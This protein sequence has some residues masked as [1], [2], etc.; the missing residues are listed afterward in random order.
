[1]PEFDIDAA[2]AARDVME[3]T[4]QCPSGCGGVLVTNGYGSFSSGATPEAHIWVNCSRRGLHT[5]HDFKATYRFVG[6]C[7]NRNPLPD[8]GRTHGQ[9]PVCE[10]VD[11]NEHPTDF[12]AVTVEHGGNAVDSLLEKR[13]F[14]R[15]RCRVER[16][17]WSDVYEFVRLEEEEDNDA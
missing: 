4:N 2:L 7:I 1:M 14:S 9:C 3:F 17:H 8:T 10:A 5:H 13:V 12:L 6:Q 15:R 16:H 11:E